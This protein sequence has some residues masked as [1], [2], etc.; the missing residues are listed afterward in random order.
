[1]MF[2]HDVLRT[3]IRQA[4]KGRF[5]NKDMV[6]VERRKFFYDAQIARAI[7]QIGQKCFGGYQVMTGYQTDGNVRMIDVP[8]VFGSMSRVVA[9]LFG[10]GGD[11]VVPRLPVMS[12]TITAMKRKLDE[13]RDPYSVVQQLV[14][15]RAR[16]ADGNLLVNQPGKIVVVE[17]AMPVPFDVELELAIWPSNYDQM[18]Q[19]VEQITAVFNPDQ[20]IMLSNSPLDWTSPTRVLFAGNVAF[21]EVIQAE[22]PDPQQI[23]R[24]QFTTTVRISLPVRVYD[25]DLIHKIDVNIREMDD[26][27]FFYFGDNLEVVDMPLLDSMEIKAKPKEIEEAGDQ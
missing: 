13:I 12:Y 14:R 23:C 10:G 2:S 21:E 5:V 9:Q 8:V 20:E 6:E 18:M 4:G 7:I 27:G 17:S 15:L 22:N 25:A 19:L 1:M 3:P 26:L 16:D 24:M 11:N